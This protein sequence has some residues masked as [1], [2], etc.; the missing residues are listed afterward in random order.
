VPE[1]LR[2]F[3]ADVTAQLLLHQ[4]RNSTDEALRRV[5]ETANE[6]A[7]TSER[8]CRAVVKARQAGYSWRRIGEVSGV[9]YQSLHRKFAGGQVAPNG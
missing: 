9:P 3:D 5:A 4:G 6:V 7:Q 2:L 8:L 1:E